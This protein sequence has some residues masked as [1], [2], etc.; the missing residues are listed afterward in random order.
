M[1]PTIEIS[2]ENVNAWFTSTNHQNLSRN[3]NNV[4]RDF[5][6]LDDVT[7][8]EDG[9]DVILST[10]GDIKVIIIRPVEEIDSEPR[11]MF[12]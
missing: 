2:S 5:E 8:S 9:Y 7:P 12:F 3:L 1:N 10:I 11:V 4:I 6:F